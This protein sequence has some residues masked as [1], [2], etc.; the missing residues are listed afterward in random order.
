MIHRNRRGSSFCSAQNW[1]LSLTGFMKIQFSGFIYSQEKK[2]IG[3]IDSCH[4]GL[5][6]IGF[7]SDT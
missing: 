6:I 1:W 4:R 2:N 7:L 3:F 5:K